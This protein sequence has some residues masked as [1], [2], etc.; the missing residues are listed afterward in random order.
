MLSTQQP[1]RPFCLET[2]RF[3]NIDAPLISGRYLGEEA[4]RI[5]D[6]FEDAYASNELDVQYI[7]FP[8]PLYDFMYQAECGDVE[9]LSTPIFDSL[10]DDPAYCL[11]MLGEALHY[12]ED[13]NVLAHTS[14]VDTDEEEHATGMI[15]TFLWSAAPW[16]PHMIANQVAVDPMHTLVFSTP[17]GNVFALHASFRDEWGALYVKAIE[18]WW[19]ATV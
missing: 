18:A 5:H 4:P 8:T 2:H 7:R 3:V 19:K 16:R 14:W 17:P 6:H 1:L 12:S 13:A 9:N 11:L 15:S 10:V